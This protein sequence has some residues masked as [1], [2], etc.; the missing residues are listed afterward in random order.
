MWTRTHRHKTPRRADA[1]DSLH[2]LPHPT[3]DNQQRDD[4]GQ[5]TSTITSA[6]ATGP[7]SAQSD[8][9]VGDVVAAP[10]VATQEAAVVQ[11]S[12]KTSLEHILRR[13]QPVSGHPLDINTTVVPAEGA[14]TSQADLDAALATIAD[15][16]AVTALR[17][18]FSHTR[19]IANASLLDQYDMIPDGTAGTVYA[20]HAT[21]AYR[22][23]GLSAFAA[24]RT[25]EIATDD[26][27]PHP[28]FV[29]IPR[30]VWSAL[31]TVG[32]DWTKFVVLDD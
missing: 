5:L 20:D 27:C 1:K 7:A 6:E 4:M 22:L 16:A 19:P 28:V 31:D 17:I 18:N 13:L 26:G 32:G 8:G 10:A 2:T 29:S 23:T 15:P 14:V 24:L 30:A 12:R 21:N 11:E 3:D 9:I 25:I